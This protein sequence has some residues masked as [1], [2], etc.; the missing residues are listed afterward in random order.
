MRQIFDLLITWLSVRMDPS[1]LCEDG[2]GADAVGFT[3]LGVEFYREHFGGL[4][5]RIITIGKCVIWQD[6]LEY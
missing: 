4:D 3:L 1:Y 6:A 2:S 5:L